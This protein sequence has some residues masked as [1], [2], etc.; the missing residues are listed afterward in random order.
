[1]NIQAGRGVAIREFPLKKGH[2][3]ADYLLYINSKA[4]GVMVVPLNF[5]K[6]ISR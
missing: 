6:F 1:V 2:G 4:A 3:H 5:C